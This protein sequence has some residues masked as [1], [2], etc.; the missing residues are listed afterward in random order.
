MTVTNKLA[1]SSAVSSCALVY[2]EVH[3]RVGSKLAHKYYVIV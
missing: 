3:A 1:Y 2:Y